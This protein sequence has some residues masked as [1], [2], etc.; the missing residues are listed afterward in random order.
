MRQT[1]Q[2]RDPARGNKASKPLAVK[3]CG[4][5]SVGR[6]SHP[7]QQ[8]VGETHRALE[9][10]QGYPSGNQHQKGPICLWVGGE[11]TKSQQRAE[12]AALF[13]V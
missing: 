12:Q 9:H 6:N 8:F 7:C 5:C 1:A 2:P 3:I 13:P 11:V 10:T 4:G